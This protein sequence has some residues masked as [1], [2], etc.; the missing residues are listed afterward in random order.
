[1]PLVIGPLGTSES[2]P[3]LVGGG[4]V[5]NGPTPP[6]FYLLVEMGFTIVSEGFFSE[7]LGNLLRTGGC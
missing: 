7:V 2:A 5:V 6:S 1:M 4:S 3:I